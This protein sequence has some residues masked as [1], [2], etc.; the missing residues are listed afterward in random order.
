MSDPG[1]DETA[2]EAIIEDIMRVSP[3]T[4]KVVEADQ[5]AWGARK[6]SSDAVEQERMKGPTRRKQGRKTR[7]SLSPSPQRVSD[8]T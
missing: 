8:V 1:S 3:E 2:D 7:G 6:P 4:A 5:L